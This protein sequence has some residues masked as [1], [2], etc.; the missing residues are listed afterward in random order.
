MAYEEGVAAQKRYYSLHQRYEVHRVFQQ[1]A[2]PLSAEGASWSCKIQ[3]EGG[4]AGEEGDE[5]GNEGASVPVET[6]VIGGWGVD[7][8]RGQD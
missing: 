3:G 5:E 6:L 8:C 4:V 7:G 2:G 1:G